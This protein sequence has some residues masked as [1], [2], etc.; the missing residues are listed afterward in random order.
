MISSTLKEKIGKLPVILSIK[1]CA[2]FFSIHYLTVYRMIRS[3]E[4]EAWKDEEGNW[5][6]LRDDLKKYCSKQSNL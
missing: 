6:V 4:L 2:A 5:C 1:E 3:G